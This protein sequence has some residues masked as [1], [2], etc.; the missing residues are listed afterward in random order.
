MFHVTRRAELS[1]R[2]KHL[3]NTIV[4]LT[5]T[6]KQLIRRRVSL[7]DRLKKVEEL[8][9]NNFEENIKDMPEIMQQFFISNFNNNKRNKHR[10][11]YSIKDKAFA[12]ALSKRGP[13]LY[14]F[15]ANIFYLPSVETLRKFMREI[16]INSGLSNCIFETLKAKIATFKDIKEKCCV[17]LFDEVKLS[18]G[19]HYNEFVDVVEGFVDN[20]FEREFNIADHAQ[21]WLLKGICGRRPWKQPLVYTFCNGTSSWQSIARMYKEIVQRCHDIDLI[22]VASICDQGATNRRAINTMIFDSKRHAQTELRDDIIIINNAEVI[23]LYDMLHLAKCIRN[24]TVTKDCE[25]IS[26]DGKTR[27]AKWSHVIDTY[28]IDKSRG[29]N[30]FLEKI[31]DCHVIPEKIKKMKVRYCAQVF[32]NTYAKTMLLYS[33]NEIESKCKTKKMPVDGIDTAIFLQF[34][35]DLFDSLNGGINM[36]NRRIN[37][38]TMTSTVTDDCVDIWNKGIQFLKN[39]KFIKKKL[40]DKP[41][42]EVLVNFEKTLRGFILLRKRLKDLGFLSFATREF[43]QDP[44]ENFFCQIRQHGGRNNNPTCSNFS[45]YY[46]SLVIQSCTQ[47][48][49]RGCNCEPIDIENLINITTIPSTT[50][51]ETVTMHKDDMYIIPEDIILQLFSEVKVLNIKNII[52]KVSS[53]VKIC[54]IC[55]AILNKEQETVLDYVRKITVII[56]YFLNNFCH[57][58]NI[59][60]NIKDNIIKY[61]IHFKPLIECQQKHIEEYIINKYLI[62]HIR[63]NIKII[64][65]ILK[66]IDNNSAVQTNKLHTLAYTYYK[67]HCKQKSQNITEE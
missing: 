20:G 65:N 66:G 61:N 22:I 4:S 38:K 56:D 52:D 9:K 1:S 62:I 27:V 15:L 43:N 47:S 63:Q 57:V 18:S 32:S 24:N 55:C 33:E 23:P 41:R 11:Q 35:N 67:K 51:D 12:L 14:K 3:Y 50:T 2:D 45:D 7:Y 37:P 28:I 58:N 64:N 44:L 40:H 31:N 34:F 6:A 53:A 29:P 54:D 8:A 10:F 39:M 17:L 48:Y 16:P 49:T 26:E 46:R 19:L 13:K 21:V 5:K 30:R 42:P 25:Y 36:R 60:K 59:V